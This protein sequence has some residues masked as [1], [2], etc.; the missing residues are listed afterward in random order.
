MPYNSLKTDFPQYALLLE[1]IIEDMPL[2]ISVVDCKDRF[3]LINRAYET[4]FDVRRELL[5]GQ[6]LSC[7]L[8][9]GDES[10]HQTVQRTGHYASTI[11]LSGPKQR[12]VQI[13]CYPVMNGESLICSVSVIHELSG[14]ERSMAALNEARQTI[15]EGK[16]Q[17]AAYTFD[18]ILHASAVMEQTIGRARRAA[19]T[20]ENILLRG[21]SGTGKELFAHA[22]HNA[23]ARRQKPFISVNCSSLPENLLSSILFG[24]AGH[25]F[26][27]AKR[28]GEVGLFEAANNGTLFLDEIGD[29]S[30]PL[31]LSLLRVLQE[32]EITR[33]GDTHPRRVN[34][35]V[36]AATNADLE[37]RIAAGTFRTDLYYRLNVFPVSI[38][39]L[40]ERREDIRLLAEQFLQEYSH[41][42]GRH[43]STITV[44]GLE[45][46]FAHSWAGNVRELKNMMARSVLEAPAKATALDAAA[47]CGLSAAPWRAIAPTG[48]PTGK[49]T[50]SDLFAVWEASMLRQVYAEEK[51]NKSA[52][53][54]RL[55]L[56][57]R[58]VY[59][60][61]KT[62]GID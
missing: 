59:Q 44:E 45:R 24:Y 34:V 14:V 54:R 3:T 21:E 7:R 36:I 29:I 27:G 6:H 62:Y 4:T 32:G 20:D 38:P 22:I 35:R 1:Q 28:E 2:P 56:S 52:V 13:E 9:E 26:T 5:L 23:S 61:L 43:I 31:Q 47:L 11:R 42:Y 49:E 60:K 48:A 8:G 33:V 53:A 17:K 55:G 12:L 40:R 18:D 39:P 51:H 16:Q 41:K 37:G 50:Y 19:A 30:I 10:I 57:V 15:Q 46:L 58:S 25:A